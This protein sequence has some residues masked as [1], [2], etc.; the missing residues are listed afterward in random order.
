MSIILLVCLAL[1][2]FLV[3]ETKPAWEWFEHINFFSYAFAALQLSQFEGLTL[4]QTNGTAIS[5]LV[6][7]LKAMGRIRSNLTMWQNIGVLL[8][9]LFVLR[10]SCYI[11]QSYKLT[12]KRRKMKY[13]NPNKTHAEIDIKIETK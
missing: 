8:G 4:Y 1:G 13:Q 5:D 2:G 6:P 10:M 9:M 7:K 11:A 12:N 3:S